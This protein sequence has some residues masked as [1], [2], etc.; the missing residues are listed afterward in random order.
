MIASQVRLHNSHVATCWNQFLTALPSLKEVESCSSKNG[1]RKFGW[2]FQYGL[3]QNA[4]ELKQ[5]EK[6]ILSQPTKRQAYRPGSIN[7]DINCS[8]RST[9]CKNG[10]WMYLPW[11]D[12]PDRILMLQQTVWRLHR[13]LTVWFFQCHSLAGIYCWMPCS[14]Y[15]PILCFA[16]GFII[17][18]SFSQAPFLHLAVH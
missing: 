2:Y 5:E 8:C 17:P 1:S 15:I 18:W 16:I 10:V 9:I 6:D 14:D 13:I 7:V 12:Q 4:T 3:Y 11:P